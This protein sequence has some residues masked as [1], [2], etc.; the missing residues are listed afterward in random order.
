M[1]LLFMIPLSVVR[2]LSSR[3]SLA[4]TQSGPSQFGLDNAADDEDFQA[5]FYYN[6]NE[7]DDSQ[8][9]AN[10]PSPLAFGISKSLKSLAFC[11]SR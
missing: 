7:E 2:A 8:T 11:D 1:I 9:V 5:S 4:A 10:S 3:H 6:E